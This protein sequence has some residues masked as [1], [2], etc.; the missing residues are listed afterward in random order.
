MKKRY[1][2]AVA[3]IVMADSAWALDGRCSG[4]D[5][6]FW[7]TLLSGYPTLLGFGI[8]GGIVWSALW[9]LLTW[10]ICVATKGRRCKTRPRLLLAGGIAGSVCF[11]LSWWFFWVLSGVC[12]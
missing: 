3:L 8:A 10:L 11:V 5:S 12:F 1:G 9:G 4:R 7:E 2:P 6:S